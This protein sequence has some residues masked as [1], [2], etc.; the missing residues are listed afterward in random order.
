M[1]KPETVARKWSVKKVFWKIWQNSQENTCARA[2][3][4]IKLQVYGLQLC[5]KKR[6]W[7][8]YFPVNFTKF[9][10]TADFTILQN[11]SSV[12]WN[13]K[14][15]QFQHGN[16]RVELQTL[17]QIKVWIKMWVILNFSWAAFTYTYHLLYY[18]FLHD[19]LI[20]PRST[21]TW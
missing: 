10:R 21:C 16:R 12:L 4:L 15:F 13:S 1:E 20:V 2:S 5:L 14:M 6:L 11:T 7:Q 8:R 9:F 17:L 18:M 3:C 19:V